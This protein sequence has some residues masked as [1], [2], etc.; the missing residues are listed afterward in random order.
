MIR[1][2]LINY[3][4]HCKRQC[5]LFAHNIKAEHTS[6]LVK[7]GKYYHQ[8]FEAEAEDEADKFLNG[9][10]VDKIQGD[11]VIEFKKSKADEQAA[12]W[13]LLFYLW[14]LKEVGI[15]KKGKLKY[16][17]NRN[18]REVL[19][20][21]AREQQLQQMIQEIEHLISSDRIPPVI[22]K[23][24]CRKCAYYEFCYT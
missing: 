9:V 13:Q 4:L 11:Y 12:E 23:Q 18:D 7:I 24:K 20:T 10:K 19:L 14:K 6:D 2:T 16:K 3:Y 5:Y 22:N 15:F 17:E 1:G 21:P 8:E